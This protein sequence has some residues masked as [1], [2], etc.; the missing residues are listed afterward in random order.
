MHPHLRAEPKCVLFL[1]VVVAVV[2]VSSPLSSSSF[3]FLLAAAVPPPPIAP[4]FI[5]AAMIDVGVMV[6]PPA[7]SRNV[8]AD[9]VGACDAAGVDAGVVES[10]PRQLLVVAEV[11]LN[12][13]N[14][15]DHPPH[16]A[17]T[18]PSYL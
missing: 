2:G 11:N 10:Y 15:S 6:P 17:G 14:V 1:F 3:L 4:A 8:D 18:R 13:P 5:D 7:P 16:S 12:L 9:G